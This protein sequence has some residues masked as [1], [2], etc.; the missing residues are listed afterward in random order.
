MVT[1]YA[2]PQCVECGQENYSLRLMCLNCDDLVCEGCVDIHL[3][4]HTDR[5]ERVVIKRDSI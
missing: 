4:S 2:G 5:S 3:K 1:E